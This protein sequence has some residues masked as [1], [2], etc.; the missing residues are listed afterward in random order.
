MQFAADGT[1]L[2]SLGADS[3]VVAWD[4]GSAR[5]LKQMFAGT[6]DDWIWTVQA[7]RADGKVAA[8][9]GSKL[10]KDTPLSRTVDPAIRLVDLA[11][12]KELQALKAGELVRSVSFSR[13]GKLVAA[14]GKEGIRV[15]E[16]ASSKEVLMLPG[17][18]PSSGRLVFSPD[19]RLLAWAGETD[20]VP[21]ICDIATGKE[22]QHWDAAKQEKTMLIE[23]APDGKSLATASRESNPASKWQVSLWSVA[24]GHKLAGFALPKTTP[25]LL[26]FSPSGRLLAISGATTAGPPSIRLWETYSGQE[27]CVISS[28]QITVSSLAFAPDGR[29]LAS[30][31][32]DST[33]LLWDLTNSSGSAKKI[34]SAKKYSKLCGP[35]WKAMRQR[36]TRRCGPLS[37]LGL[38]A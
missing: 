32:G 4:V 37:A 27:A 14:D 36:Q 25:Q 7:V 24:T 9:I 11:T 20:R 5:E 17:Q 33:I 30:G 3:R 2:I 34:R 38:R 22:T 35:I 1:T 13:D 15:W 16:A 29:S 6:S 26:A 10:S 8:V 12:G 23:F 31:S 19:A 28:P 21:H 18:H